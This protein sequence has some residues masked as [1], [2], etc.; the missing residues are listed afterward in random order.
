MWTTAATTNALSFRAGS[1]RSLPRTCPVCRPEAG[2]EGEAGAIN[3][4]QCRLRT[5][6]IW[7]NLI[8]RHST[9]L[10]EDLRSQFMRKAADNYSRVQ[11]LKRIEK[12]LGPKKLGLKSV[13]TT[14]NKF[15]KLYSLHYL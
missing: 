4:I 3:L 15:K 2:G 11:V 8:I 7:S 13:T 1:T 9:H 5:D 10:A 6:S 14:K 12:Y